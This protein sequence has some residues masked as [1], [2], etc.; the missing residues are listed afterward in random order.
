MFI[1]GICQYWQNSYCIFIGYIGNKYWL[2]FGNKIIVDNTDLKDPSLDQPLS[3]D[4]V[5]V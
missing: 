4:L 2:M 3:G 1:L 5:F